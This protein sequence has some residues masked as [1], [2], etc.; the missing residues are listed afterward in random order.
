[1]IV[2]YFSKYEKDLLLD[3]LFENNQIFSSLVELILFSG[4]ISFLLL[5][6]FKHKQNQNEHALNRD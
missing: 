6:V 3:I 2:K 5:V 1:M 4:Y